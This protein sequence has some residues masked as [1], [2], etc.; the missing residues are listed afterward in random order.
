M[1]Q[2]DFT[3]DELAILSKVE[4]LEFQVVD[5][6]AKVDLVPESFSEDYAEEEQLA[7]F[8]SV[9]QLMIA[10]NGLMWE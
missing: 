5:M 10:L 9:D 2:K 6:V 4:S 8:D 7:Q 1:E 3:Q